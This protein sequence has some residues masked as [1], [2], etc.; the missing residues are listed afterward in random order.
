MTL[1]GN[2]IADGMEQQMRKVVHT[3]DRNVCLGTNF[4]LRK[5]RERPQGYAPCAWPEIMI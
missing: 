3:F 2:T 5:V 1:D 4:R